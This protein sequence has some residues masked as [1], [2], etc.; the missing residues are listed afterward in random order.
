MET[1][2]GT[3]ETMPNSAVGTLHCRYAFPA[4]KRRAIIENNFGT[5]SAGQNLICADWEPASVFGLD[6]FDRDVRNDGS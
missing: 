6:L 3:A 5:H 1:V 2:S 4:L